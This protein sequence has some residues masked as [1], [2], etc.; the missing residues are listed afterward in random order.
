MPKFIIRWNT[1]YGDSHEV[2]EAD[3]DDHAQ[4]LAYQA[5]REAAENGADYGTMEYTE[6]NCDA[7]DL[8]FTKEV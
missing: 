1:G 4:E 8:D 7:F 2:V 6:A 3:D 5:W